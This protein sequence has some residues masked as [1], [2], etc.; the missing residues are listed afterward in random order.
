[1]SIFNV[2]NLVGGLALFLFGMNFMGDALEKRAGGTLQT[3]LSRITSNK[4]K[5]LLLGVAVTAVIQS[6]SATTV[7]VVGFV[8][9]GIMVLGQAI[10]VIMG[11]NI[12]TTVTSWLLSLTGIESDNIFVSLLKPSSFT[13][14]L[15]LIGIILFMFLK[16]NKSKDIGQILLGFAVLMFGMEAMSDAV[17]PLKDVPEF[18]NILLMF[19]NPILG[20]IAGAVLTAIIQSSS[21][22]VGILQAL[23][24]T[25][26]ITFGSAIP[27]IMGQNIGTCVTALISSIGANKGAKRSAVVHL[28]F[29][30]GGTIIWLSVF[31]LVNLFV[32]FDFLNDQIG[33]MGIA[34][35]HTIFNVLCTLTFLPFTKKLEKLA[36]LIVRDDHKDQKFEVL[37]TRLYATPAVALENCAKVVNEMANEAVSSIKDAFGLLMKYDQAVAEKIKESEKT[38]DKYEDKIA[39]YLLGLS[40][41]SI[42]EKDS[43]AISKYLH[44]IGDIE[45]MSDHSVSLAESARE[46]RDKKLTFSDSAKAEIKTMCSALIEI[47]DYTLK[48]VSDNDLI[49]AAEI[50]PLEEVIDALKNKLQKNHIKRL[51]NNGCTIEMGFILSDITTVMER[52]SDHCNKIALCIIEIQRES[53]GLHQQS[54][55]LKK[56]N[57]LFQKKYEEYYEKYMTV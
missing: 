39:N 24:S 19:S 56:S 30:I 51:Q 18:Q 50:G 16:S 5:G 14:V 2:L 25:G 36:C 54:K 21:A 41:L 47:L 29:N 38:V 10:N 55:Y 57:P 11:A 1:M 13:P 40:S 20:V 22:S 34:F 45:R 8:N 49:S 15:A 12:G 32:N 33:V 23:S 28:C 7:M 31:E 6:S 27:I 9:S 43:L 48:T 3:V 4:W 44:I 37:D 52:V 35:V 26:Q 53:L 42:S 17:A 46:I